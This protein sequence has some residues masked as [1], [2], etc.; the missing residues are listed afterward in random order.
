M[1][2]IVLAA[3]YATRLYPL[4]KDQPKPLLEVAGKT[5]LDYIAEKLEKVDEIDEVI[6]VTNNKFTSH[7]EEWVKSTNYTKKLTVVND[8]TMT[9]DTRLGAIGDIQYVID[10]LDVSDD[11]MVLA[12]DNLFDFELSDFA[13]YFQEVGTDCITA[14]HEQNE[15]QLKRAGVIE[16][17]NHQNVLSFEEKPEQPRSTYCVPAFY[18]YKKE[19]LP[20]FHKYLEDGNNP[21]AP[22]HFVPYLI[23]QKEVHA[24]LFKGRRY[25]IGTVESY[26]A[27]QDI[28]E[29]AES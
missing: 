10:Q 9:N 4:T 19:T 23:K 12:G 16:L 15:A 21:D 17:D 13:N 28:F 29:K 26:Q 3:G 24:Y 11:L 14:Y 27:V 8:G 5:I 2:A 7:F 25:D 1:K 6:I 22:G 20:Y 18:L